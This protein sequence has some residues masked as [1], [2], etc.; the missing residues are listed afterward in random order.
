M[1]SISWL[2]FV[3]AVPLIQGWL[4]YE[5]HFSGVVNEYTDGQSCCK[6]QAIIG[7]A[8]L[9]ALELASRDEPQDSLGV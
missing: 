6:V 8:S 7:L 4:G 1:T 9:Q 3:A 2:L 5:S